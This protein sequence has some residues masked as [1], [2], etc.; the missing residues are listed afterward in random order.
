MQQ[1]FPYQG[2]CLK[3]MRDSRA[4]LSPADRAFVDSAL[5]ATGADAIFSAPALSIHAR[6]ESPAAQPA[7]TSVNFWATS[8]FFR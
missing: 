5:K 1:P 6:V 7:A 4:A 3:W 2:K 8:P